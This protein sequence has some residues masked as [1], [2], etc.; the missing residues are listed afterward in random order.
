L[1][2]PYGGPRGYITRFTQEFTLNLGATTTCGAQMYFP[3]QELLTGFTAA[4]PTASVAISTA[5]GPGSAFLNATAANVRAVSAC[6]ELIPSGATYNNLS[7]EIGFGFVEYSTAPPGSTSTVDGLITLCPSRTVLA[8]RQYECKWVPGAVDHLYSPQTVGGS[9]TPINQSVRGMLV[10]WKGCPAGVAMT[11]RLTAVLEWT[12]DLGVG[13]AANAEGAV[14]V[15]H[16]KQSAALSRSHGTHWWNN[17]LES[18][19]GVATRFATG[20]MDDAASAGRYIVRNKIVQNLSAM[21]ASSAM[22]LL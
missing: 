17:L 3:G 22:M 14:P 15:D 18:A 12:P 1:V 9:A 11:L 4:L 8:K 10:V 5:N 7:G 21:G 6:M 19:G 2:S 20:L 16:L 13:L